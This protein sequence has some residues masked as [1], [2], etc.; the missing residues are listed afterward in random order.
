M[1][2]ISHMPHMDD[3]LEII[4]LSIHARYSRTEL[5]ATFNVGKIMTTQ[6]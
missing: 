4:P 1:S 6:P 2:I 3:L 5:L